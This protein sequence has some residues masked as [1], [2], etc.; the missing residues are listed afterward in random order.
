M[1]HLQQAKKKKNLS[2]FYRRAHGQREVTETIQMTRY[3]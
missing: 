1:Q 3:S 2:D